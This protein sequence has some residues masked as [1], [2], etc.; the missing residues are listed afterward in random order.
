M[1]LLSPLRAMGSSV[2]HPSQA[3]GSQHFRD[4]SSDIS[5]ASAQSQ[6]VG[7]TSFVDNDGADPS[8]KALE[9]GSVFILV[10]QDLIFKLYS[11][12]VAARTT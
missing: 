1:L 7:F 8:R 12:S 11:F 3:I 5:A 2:F 4:A 6:E 9:G 10:K